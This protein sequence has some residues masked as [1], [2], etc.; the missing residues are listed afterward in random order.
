[1]PRMSV[2]AVLLGGLAGVLAMIGIALALAILPLDALWTS[3]VAGPAPTTSA[4]PRSA[5]GTDPGS[6]A[7]TVEGPPPLA[8][9]VSLA[10][11][12]LAVGIGGYVAARIARR[13]ELAHGALAAWPVVLGTV[14]A[15]V[16]QGP[17][18]AEWSRLVEGVLAPL[19][20]AVGGYVSRR[21]GS[22]P[23]HDP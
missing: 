14:A 15:L 13:V 7:I 19:A 6:F 22:G 21:R 17:R 18:S 1:M 11:T 5:V 3:D 12:L 2:K 9:G 10:A 23:E 20:G 4:A 16:S 8:P